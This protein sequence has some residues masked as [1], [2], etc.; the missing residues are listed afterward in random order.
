M[1][2]VL[3][4]DVDTLMRAEDSLNSRLLS[5][6]KWS[7]MIMGG[8]Q[9]KKEEEDE[10]DTRSQSQKSF[11]MVDLPGADPDASQ[12]MQGCSDNDLEDF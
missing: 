3:R 2:A 8:F 11:S 7:L 5:L 10:E 4:E 1:I 9:D 6:E 12:S